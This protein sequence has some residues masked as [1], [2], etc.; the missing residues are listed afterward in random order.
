MEFAENETMNLNTAPEGVISMDFLETEIGSDGYDHTSEP[1]SAGAIPPEGPYWFRFEW[2]SKEGAGDINPTTNL[3][4]RWKPGVSKPK[5]AGDTPKRFIGTS[6]KGRMLRPAMGSTLTLEEFDNL[7]LA[8]RQYSK[9]VSTMVMFG[10]TSLTDFLNSV[11]QERVPENT[12]IVDLI[13]LAEE[14]MQQ[15]PEGVGTIRHV[16]YFKDETDEKNP[17]EAPDGYQSRDEGQ[18]QAGQQGVS[19]GRRNG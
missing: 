1:G 5:K 6:I 10:R 11:L 4:N 7:G 17:L 15:V 12:R 2:P 18:V 13:G 9:Y 19:Q 3:P 8:N 16:A 14:V